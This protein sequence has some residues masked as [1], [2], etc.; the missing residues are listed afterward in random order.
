MGGS[1]VTV[2][3]PRTDG[4]LLVD[5]EALKIELQIT[6]TVNDDYLE[7]LLLRVSEAIEQHCNRVFA[8]ETVS[9]VIRPD[10][11]AMPRDRLILTRA[12]VLAFT[13]VTVDSETLSASDY[14]ADNEA[15]LIYR[16]SADAR[17]SWSGA[18]I[19]AVYS[20]GF[21]ALPGP[22]K[23]GIFEL[24]KL[25][26]AARTRDPAL[27]SENILEGL[28]SYTLFNG[29]NLSSVLDGVSGLDKYINR[30]VA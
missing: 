29:E 6:T 26:Q 20:T 11:C 19:T 22:V 10:P 18:K 8:V 5:L 9:E 7:S 24:I 12:P 30:T 4:G 23:D 15:G 16:L 25:R 27:R 17:T 14:E 13:S 3:T 1:I 21:A 28:Y 2:T